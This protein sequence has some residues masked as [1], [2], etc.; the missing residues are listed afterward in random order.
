MN[1]NDGNFDVCCST[2][3]S[4]QLQQ[5]EYLPRI[6]TFFLHI[7]VY[8]KISFW[9][10]FAYISHFSNTFV[11][12]Q[13]NKTPKLKLLHP[14]KTNYSHNKLIMEMEQMELQRNFLFF[15][16]INFIYIKK[17]NK[18]ILYFRAE[19]T[20]PNIEQ[21]PMIEQCE[22]KESVCWSVGKKL[23]ICL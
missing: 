9:N 16:E 21:L 17:R 6:L 20:C 3:T 10:Y 22:G 13:L 2:A 11:Y 23:H 4:G 15:H 5:Q 1:G 7:F 18:L 14:I 8:K 19:G 12:F